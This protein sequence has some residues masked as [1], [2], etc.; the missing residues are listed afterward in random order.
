MNLKTRFDETLGNKEWRMSHLYEFINKDGKKAVFQR[1][2]AQ[3]D[4]NKNRSDRNIVLKSRQLGFTTDEAL[5]ALDDV[6]FIP[7][8]KALM[9]SYDIASQLDI[10]D[11]K[12]LYAWENLV[13]WFEDNGWPMQW[14]PD[15][16]R[17]NQLKLRFPDDSQSL[18]LVRTKGRSGTFNRVHVSELGKI[19]KQDPKKAAEILSGTIPAVPMGGRVDIESTAEGD[20]GLFHDLFWEAWDR[21]EPETPVDYKAHFYNWQ[22]DKGEIS[23]ITQVA[24]D[25]PQEFLD[26]QKKHN[27]LASKDS[28]YQKIDDIQ[29]TYY[30]YKWVSLNKRWDVLHQEYPTTPE[31]AFV[32][33]GSKLFSIEKIGQMPDE[34][35]K[36]VGDWIYYNDYVPG[37]RYA[38]AGD[39]AEGVGRNNSTASLIDFDHTVQITTS[40]GELS[41]KRPKLVAEYASS[42]ISPAD[43]AFEL[44]NGGRAYGNCIIAVERNS[45][46]LATITKLKD[47]Y[48]NIYKEER[49]G[50]SE[51]QITK[52]YGYHTNKATKPK[53]LWDLDHAINHDEILV[54]SKPTK[55]ELKSYDKEDLGQITFD[56]DA[57]HHWDRV[58]SLAICYQMVEHA[59]PTDLAKDIHTP[60]AVEDELDRYDVI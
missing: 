27:E 15:T 46:G 56:E 41:F 7:N 51:R 14:K 1:N 54:T 34:E 28:R 43:F 17:A 13:G 30:Y 37:H 5:D 16:Q 24:S 48:G 57:Q 60:L 26:Y 12:I 32:S 36:R 23:K 19:A 2:D 29:L 55:R 35:G 11:S 52:T 44:R 22:W 9:L 18:I 21:G 33:S 40:E 3:K 25:M 4:F 50:K 20:Y 49:P 31:E 59:Y 8:F 47:I 39:P 53:M 10:F 58:I 45:S 38:L 6:L 42:R